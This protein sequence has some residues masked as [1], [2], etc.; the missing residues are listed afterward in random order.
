MRAFHASDSDF[1]RAVR[2]GIVPEG[3][4]RRQRSR[5][6]YG[7]TFDDMHHNR[8]QPNS[9][10]ERYIESGIRRDENRFRKAYVRKGN[11]LQ[12]GLAKRLP[13]ELWEKIAGYLD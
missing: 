12:Q 1:N 10:R 5:T 7:R 4:Y 3:F 6:H 13:H 9:R 2:S 8:R 11:R